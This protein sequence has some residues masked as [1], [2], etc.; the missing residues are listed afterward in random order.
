MFSVKET[1]ENS[2][3]DNLNG[4]G[5]LGLPSSPCSIAL[6]VFTNIRQGAHWQRNNDSTGNWLEIKRMR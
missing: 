6:F 1:L 2:R 3:R 4:K 5:E